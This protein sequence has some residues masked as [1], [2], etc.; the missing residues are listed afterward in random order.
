[1][2]R[3]KVDDVRIPTS[4]L[5]CV[6]W[7]AL[8]GTRILIDC[9]ETR[10]TMRLNHPEEVEVLELSPSHEYVKIHARSRGYCFPDWIATRD[11]VN[12]EGLPPLPKKVEEDDVEPTE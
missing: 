3:K 1:M 7:K 5:L 8:V 2:A 11:I 4:T 12:V 9:M 10:S 6:N